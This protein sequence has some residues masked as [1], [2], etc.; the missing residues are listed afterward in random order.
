[1]AS[2]ACL[3]THNQKD[4][5]AFPDYPPLD[6]KKELNTDHN[7]IYLPDPKNKKKEKGSQW[8]K[9]GLE[10]LKMYGGKIEDKKLGG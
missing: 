1:M 8:T 10:I 3:H 6:A 2:G 9:K 4:N 7:T 5:P